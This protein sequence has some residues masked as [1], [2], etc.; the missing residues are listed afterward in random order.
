MFEVILIIAIFCTWSFGCI[1]CCCEGC[2]SCCGRLP[3]FD[4]EMI[5]RNHSRQDKRDIENHLKTEYDLELIA[6]LENVIPT[7]PVISQPMSMKTS[8]T[9]KLPSMVTPMMFLPVVP[10]DEKQTTETT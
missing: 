10:V 2:K 4:Q 8:K 9:F 5:Q 7:A 3:S 6:R 1:E